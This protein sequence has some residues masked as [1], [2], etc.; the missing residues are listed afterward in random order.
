MA[1]KKG[2]GGK[3]NRSEIIQARL[4]PKIHMAAEILA[5]SQRRTLSSLIET[6]I[7]DAIKNTKIPAVISHNTQIDVFLEN[8]TERQEITI[9]E[10]VDIIW[11]PEEADR[12]A[13]FALVLPDLMT[14]DEDFL[15]FHIRTIFYFWSHVPINVVSKSG[16]VLDQQTW[17]LT[18][19]QGLVKERLREHWPFLKDILQGKES[20]EDFRSLSKELPEGPLVDKPNDFPHDIQRIDYSVD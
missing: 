13:M 8:S 9:K 14:T 2:G 5:R 11:S 16:R 3:L 7:E 12:F 19:Q 17:P 4:D 10:A 18:N 15:W 1:R 6:L 20:I